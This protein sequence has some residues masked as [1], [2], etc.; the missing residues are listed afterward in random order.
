MHRSPC[1]RTQ[2]THILA[3][4]FLNYYFQLYDTLSRDNLNKFDSAIHKA[5]FLSFHIWDSIVSTIT[6]IGHYALIRSV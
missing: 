3:F 2:C 5:Q 4:P 1:F 6:L